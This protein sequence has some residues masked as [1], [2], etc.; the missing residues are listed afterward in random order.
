MDENLHFQ[1]SLVFTESQIPSCLQFDDG[2]RQYCSDRKIL[3]QE[4]LDLL[5]T[6]FGA[7]PRQL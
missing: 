1:V 7:T 3:T 4:H 2:V 6:T 5:V